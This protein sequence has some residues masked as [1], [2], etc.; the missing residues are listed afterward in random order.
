MDLDHVAL[1]AD[2]FWRRSYGADPGV[3][4][5]TLV[6]DDEPYTVVGVLPAGLDFPDPDTDLWVPLQQE[7]TTTPRGRHWI[8]VVGRLRPGVTV[9]AAQTEMTAI[10]A[11]LEAEYPENRARGV[12]VEPLDEVLRGEVRPA[13][14]VLF[15]AVASVL[16]IACANVASLLLARG[17]GRAR[18]LAVRAALGAGARHFIRR[19]LMESTLLTAAAAALGTLL[20]AAGTRALLALAP[21][22]VAELGTA[23]DL[24]V[25]AFTLALTA[26]IALVFAL[27]PTLQA[28]RLDLERALRERATT[29]GK[30]VLRRLLVVAQM[31]ATLI[32]LVACAPVSGRPG[33]RDLQ[34]RPTKDPVSLEPRST[35]ARV[36]GAQ[37][38]APTRRPLLLGDD[39]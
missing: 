27:V 25:L 14:L 28:L 8:D 9:E 16:L 24:R 36:A 3:L 38:C 2:G 13:L 31:A 32:L 37:P 35:V 30:A 29:G 15:A 7:A 19:H 21:T 4:G 33:C 5:R 18:E 10:A 12:A 22:A 34:R 20:A 6:L 1:L 17:A 23:L 39:C 26:A 11:E